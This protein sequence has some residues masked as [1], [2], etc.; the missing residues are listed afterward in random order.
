MTMQ[1]FWD[2]VMQILNFCAFYYTIQ[3]I[4]CVL[5]S[6]AVSVVVFILRKIIS[7][8]NVFLKGALW[9]LFIPL[10]FAGKMKFFDESEIGIML[11]W[12]WKGITFNHIWIC[13]LY[14]FVMFL[15]AARLIYKKRKLKKLVA[16]MERRKVDGTFIYVTALPVTPFTIGVLR[17]RI[18]MPEVVLEEY[19]REDFQ[20]ILL[21]EKTHIRLGH[22]LFYFLWDVLRV[23]LWLNPLLTIGTKYFRGD[24]EEICD[25]VTIQ[26]NGGKAYT[27]GQLL[28]RSMK[29]LQAE[30][31]EFNMYA[32]F[33]G[34]KEYRDIRQRITGIARYKPYKQMIAVSTLAVTVLC[35]AGMI[36]GIRSISYGRNI[37]NE[38]MLVY[39]Y[40]SGKVTFTNYNS[41]VLCK[42]I[43]YDDNYVYVEREAFEKFLQDNKAAGEIF[44]VF[45]GFYKLPGVGGIGYSC[46][47]ENNTEEKT[48]QLP[49]YNYKDSWLVKLEKM[50]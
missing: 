13:W 50:L 39:G 42:M 44:I 29:V 18:V 37:E 45:G 17:P 38:S 40:D 11:S 32:N 27:Y 19:D 16:G 21:H 48:V 34:D 35:V 22:L 2:K 8:N 14:L 31:E 36:V 15:Y 20:A 30:S 12:W 47:Y 46:L 26:K 33:A 49:Y 23:L 10:L 41:D 6:F 3:I 4:R 5:L 1:V 9:A 25:W 7:K 28:L 24:M 43:S